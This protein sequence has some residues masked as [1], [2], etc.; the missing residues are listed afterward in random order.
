MRQQTIFSHIQII[1]WR[2]ADDNLVALINEIFLVKLNQNK[3]IAINEIDFKN[4][5]YIL[6]AMLSE[7]DCVKPRQSTHG[8]CRYILN[9]VAN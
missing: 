9:C 3:I 4:V 1:V 7:A 2:R 8:R 6:S 5:V